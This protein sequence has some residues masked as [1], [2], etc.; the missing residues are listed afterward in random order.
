[1]RDICVNISQNS[2]G[3]P[4]VETEGTGKVRGSKRRHFLSQKCFTKVLHVTLILLIPSSFINHWSDLAIYFWGEK[5]H[6]G[7]E[8]YSYLYKNWNLASGKLD[9]EPSILLVPNTSI[10]YSVTECCY[11]YDFKI[12]LIIYF[13][14]GTIRW[15]QRNV[16]MVC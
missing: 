13:S 14:L 8:R 11:S 5:R 4:P 6:K 15:I 3:D 10:L 12:L 1:M 9:R 2:Q 16:I 7:T